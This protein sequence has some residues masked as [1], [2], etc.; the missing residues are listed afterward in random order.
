[1]IKLR[2]LERFYPLAK[3]KFFYVLRDINLEVKR[4]ER[5][6]GQGDGPGPQ[7]DQLPHQQRSRL[8][9]LIR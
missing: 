3:E 4:S 6:V 9:P 1:M 7:L 2:H 5:I 8:I